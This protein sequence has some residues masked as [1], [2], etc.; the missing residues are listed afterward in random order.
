[1]ELIILV[2]KSERHTPCASKGNIQSFG[3]D[4]Y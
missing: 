2:D 3:A 4:C 1:M